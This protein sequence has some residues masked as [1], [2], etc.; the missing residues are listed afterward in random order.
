LS[1]ISLDIIVPLTLNN[2]KF[3]KLIG[4][5]VYTQVWLAIHQSL[6]IPLAIKIVPKKVLCEEQNMIRFNREISIL[7]QLD[8]PLV[9]QLFQVLDD[10]N[11]YYLVMEYA[12][13]GDLFHFINSRGRL[14]EP[15]ARRYFIQ[16]I[17]VL[18]YLHGTK[19]IAHRDIKAEN[20]LLDRYYNIRVIDFG[21]SNT[22]DD[23]PTFSTLC[24]SPAYVPPEM[25]KGHA[26]TTSCDIWSSGVLLYALCVG[27]LPFMDENIQIMLSK[28][29]QNEPIYPSFLS[30]SLVD[31]LSKM[32]CK[33][34]AQRITLEK[35]QEHSWFSQL[36]YNVLTKYVNRTIDNDINELQ[37]DIIQKLQK[38]KID[39]SSLKHNLFIHEFDEATTCYKM[40]KQERIT[41]EM[42]TSLRIRHQMKNSAIQ[43]ATPQ[44]IVTGRPTPKIVTNNY[45]IRRVPIVVTTP[46]T[47]ITTNSNQ[48]E[49]KN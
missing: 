23:N 15:V 5:G 4:K 20:I 3:V 9:I 21:L 49:A 38:L 34:P 18:S 6:Q 29:V 7:K 47:L 11:N 25:V 39:T 46:T 16:L 37:S 12:Q 14:L 19:K 44:P 10:K 36:E 42:K 17:S 35:I 32:L 26:Y 43:S 40:L 33:D 13:N 31:L 22:Y 27:C 1:K 45:H 41:E 28:I 30:S 8:H 24:G 2:Y 48:D